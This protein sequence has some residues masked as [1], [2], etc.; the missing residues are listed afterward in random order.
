MCSYVPAHR[1]IALSPVHFQS[2]SQRPSPLHG[3]SN[4]QAAGRHVTALKQRVNALTRQ[5]CEDLF[6]NLHAL[7]FCTFCSKTTELFL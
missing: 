1:D 6:I 3:R 2:R 7:M 5:V 4:K